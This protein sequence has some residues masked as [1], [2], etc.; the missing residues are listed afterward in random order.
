MLKSITFKG[1]AL[2]G[3]GLMLLVV[4]LAGCSGEKAG[5][6]GV[7][8]KP[9]E[10]KATS[11]LSALNSHQTAGNRDEGVGSSDLL[12][13]PAT[14]QEQQT[15]SSEQVSGL[16]DEYDVT[17][18]DDED[19]YD[20]PAAKVT[21]SVDGANDVIRWQA[22]EGVGYSNAQITVSANNSNGGQVVRNFG[23]GEAI[24]LYGS[25]PD[26]VYGWES[27]ITPEISEGVREQM[28][29]VRELGD[30]QAER[31]L[32]ANLRAEGSIPTIEDAQENRQSGTFIVSDGVVRPSSVDT[33]RSDQD[34]G[35]Y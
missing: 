19:F 20:E 27:V 32:I 28:R 34:N 4:L 7:Q 8:N 6:Q 29:A 30:A 10:I 17:A 18:D 14:E 13:Q 33:V 23:P 35:G 16:D 5:D 3:A 22:P 1:N 24:E 9:A 11:A 12:Q 25:L 2:N 26:G 21:L 31:E 15:E